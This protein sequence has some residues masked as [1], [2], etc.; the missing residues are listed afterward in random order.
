[1]LF[2]LKANLTIGRKVVNIEPKKPHCL[3]I[4]TSSSVF[5]RRLRNKKSRFRDSPCVRCCLQGC[6]LLGSWISL[7]I[8]LRKIHLISFIDLNFFGLGLRWRVMKCFKRSSSSVIHG[9]EIVTST[10]FV[11][12]LLSSSQYSTTNF[13][14]SS[15]LSH[16][17]YCTD[18][19]SEAF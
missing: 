1:M 15:F 7:F 14:F 5:F 6:A 3:K 19:L 2:I 11:C 16:C 10:T 13:M 12:C 18:F 4:S 9:S 8:S 17:A